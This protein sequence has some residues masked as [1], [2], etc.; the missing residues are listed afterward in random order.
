MHKNKSSNLFCF[1]PMSFGKNVILS[2]T[3]SK[4]VPVLVVSASCEFLSALFV[5]STAWIGS[6]CHPER[7]TRQDGGQEGR[8]RQP[9]SEAE[10]LLATVTSGFP[11]FHGGLGARTLTG[12]LNNE[13]NVWAAPAPASALTLR[14]SAAFLEN[15]LWPLFAPTTP[16]RKARTLIDVKT[17]TDRIYGWLGRLR[18]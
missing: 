15:F 5:T 2:C 14:L 7:E 18:R 13:K 16:H 12:P 9:W 8:V 4:T 17:D 10:T 3:E 6:H 1:F 11:S